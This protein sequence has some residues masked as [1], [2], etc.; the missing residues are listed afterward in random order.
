M[1]LPFRLP[2]PSAEDTE[3]VWMGS[4]FRLGSRVVRVVDYGEN[5]AGWSDDLTELHDRAA[6][7]FHPIDVASRRDAVRQIRRRVTAPR[8]T[9]LEIGCSSGYLLRD[10]AAALP[11]AVVIGADVVRGPLERL[12][13]RLPGVPLLRFD[14]QACPLPPGSVDAVVMLNVLEH[15]EDDG[16][17][18]RQ[19]HR[20]LRPGGIVVVEV[21]A[22]PQLF[23]DYDRAL[24]H[25]RRY[26]AIELAAKLEQAGFGVL[27]RSHLGFFLY[28]A[29]VLAKRRSQRSRLAPEN[30]GRHVEQQVSATASNRLMGAALTVEAVL[31]RWIGY[32][33]GIRCL[34][35]GQR[36]DPLGAHS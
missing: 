11:D 20:I 32:P 31:G 10:M 34:V 13:D 6:G 22:G 5:L 35:S 28:P 24:R 2:P 30:L 12:A 9:I 19:V 26:R 8:P 21:P 27:R 17:A 29:F 33:I 36:I 15:V 16:A 25:F 7:E 18:L 1:D 14:I 4:G 23:D 3:P